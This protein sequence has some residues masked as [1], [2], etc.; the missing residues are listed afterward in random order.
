MVKDSA[1]TLITRLIVII[2]R[3]AY[4]VIINRALGPGG[5]GFFEVIQVVPGIL[6]NFGLFG[7]DH[8]NV[9]FTGRDP[10]KIPALIANSVVLGI[11]LGIVS[12]ILGIIYYLI[13]A[14][15]YTELYEKLGYVIVWAP[16]I[17]IPLYLVS[18]YFDMI[19]YGTNRIWVRNLKEILNTVIRLVFPILFV[20]VLRM[21]VPGA[22]WA[23]IAIG[24]CMFFYSYYFLLRFFRGKLGKFDWRTV[25]ESFAFGKFE[26]GANFASYLF[27]KSDIL[28][29]FL[30]LPDGP[31]SFIGRSYGKE[32]L[33][34]FYTLGVYAI[35]L[36]WTI[37]DSITTALKPKITMKGEDERKKL[38]PPSLRICM[39]SVIA[40]SIIGALLARPVI[41][42]VFGDGSGTSDDWTPAALPFYWLIPGI[43]TLSVAKI[44]ATDLFSRGKP[45]YAMWISIFSCA[46]NIV[47]NFILIPMKGY[48]GG[49]IGAAIASSVSYTI[50]FILFCYYFRKESGFSFTTMFVPRKSDFVEIWFKLLS[51]VG[52]GKIPEEP[53]E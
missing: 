50:S 33:I 39:I 8:S 11:V 1:Q 9:Y 48:Y 43:L 26:F 28:L 34:G 13:F 22:V 32:E 16:L 20:I 23:Y 51:I 3:F 4:S 6:M 52:I 31:L 41:A 12:I 53:S 49:I 36:I 29:L 27:Y 2:G 19:V 47:L 14:E 17:I 35:T 15:K 21:W 42:I 44:F 30:L 7:F 46:V 10:K 38:V 5:K 18:V 40:I 45:Y 25:K 37:P 24:I